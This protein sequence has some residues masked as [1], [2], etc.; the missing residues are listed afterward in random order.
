[1][2]QGS[3]KAVQTVALVYI[4]VA[5]FSS[6]IHLNSIPYLIPPIALLAVKLFSRDDKL[7]SLLFI[8]S[9]VFYASRSWY[10]YLLM[11]P[12]TFL[13]PYSYD[14]KREES[15][16]EH[17][18]LGG[19]MLELMKYVIILLPVAFLDVSILTPISTLLLVCLMIS[20][21]HYI[22]LRNVTMELLEY[23]DK[24]QVRARQNVMFR[25][26]TVKP[27]Y[28]SIL[29]RRGNTEVYSFLVRGVTLVRVPIPT[30]RI[31]VH[32]I[33]ADII[34]SDQRFFSARSLGR[35]V[36]S[37]AVVP[38]AEKLAELIEKKYFSREDI[39]RIIR[40]V[41]VSVTLIGG[42]EGAVTGAGE[43]A[44]GLAASSLFES[45]AGAGYG[46]FANVL[47]LIREFVRSIE[48][49]RRQTGAE[50]LGQRT[51]I[52]EYMGVRDYVPGDHLRDIH[53]KKSL[54]KRSLVV[55]EHSGHGDEYGGA[56]EAEKLEH[57]VIAD[58]YAPNYREFDRVMSRLLL[59]FLDLLNES[60]YTRVV[61]VV[62]AGRAVLFARGRVI[63]VLYHFYR[64]LHRYLPKITY[65][66]EGIRRRVN[67]ERLA[68]MIKALKKMP[69]LSVIYEPNKYFA[70]SLVR[71]LTVKGI[72]PPKPCVVIH[73]NVFQVRYGIVKS[74]LRVH[75]FISVEYPR[76]P[77]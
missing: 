43:A 22:E 41:E 59:Y 17:G 3:S 13:I 21:Y 76:R 62:I 8:P 56:E 1:M 73:S 16:S 33:P 23:P 52:G 70:E 4:L 69:Y 9:Y 64:S 71:L 51:R 14:Y 44:E 46:G 61:L 58:L 29:L 53:W 40:E 45:A 7:V 67:S 27:A 34:V 2:Q 6:A 74:V 35:Y 37:Y 19:S 10:L 65:E 75:G 63:D 38:E 49:W 50:G 11:F 32:T 66:Y 57:V 28:V 31:R 36:I 5:G 48:E 18:F 25:V 68:D 42:A 12:F 60:I 47:D 54:S 26:S 77:Q 72:T 24:V 20:V 39:R 55:K 30:D 15:V